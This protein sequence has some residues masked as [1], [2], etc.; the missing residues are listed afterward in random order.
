METLHV[1]AHSV[2]YL[3]TIYISTDD[4]AHP[5]K[6]RAPRFNSL[7]VQNPTQFDTI[8]LCM[9]ARNDVEGKVRCNI[10]IR[11]LNANSTYPRNQ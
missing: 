5:S 11:V 1:S 9:I 3:K 10:A 8:K 7:Y 6:L 2:E 4:I